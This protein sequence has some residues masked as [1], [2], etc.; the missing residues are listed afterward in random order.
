MKNTCFYIFIIT[1]AM[2][3]VSCTHTETTYYPDGNKQSIIQ[4]RGKKEHG[5]TT[6][7]YQ[8]PNTVEIEVA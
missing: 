3:A 8:R 1:I 4:Y 2:A 5:K 7:F 6:Y